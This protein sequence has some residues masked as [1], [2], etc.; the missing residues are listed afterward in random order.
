MRSNQKRTARITRQEDTDIDQKFYP[1]L[2]DL[3]IS[4]KFIRRNAVTASSGRQRG[5]VWISDLIYSHP[6]YDR[7]IVALVECKDH[8]TNLG[9]KDWNDAVAQ[10]QQK[11]LKQGLN[12]FFVTNTDSITRCYNTYDL[13]EVSIDGTVITEIQ[14]LPV[15]KAIQT[16]VSRVNSGVKY[17]TF[18]S[19]TPDPR[20]FRASLWELRQIF[21]AGGI[22]K[23]SEDSMIKTSLTFCILKLISEQQSIRRT[24]PETIMLWDEWR[25]GQLSRDMNNTIGDIT[26]LAQYRH[27]SDCLH[28]DDR[29]DSAACLKIKEE[30]GRFR[31]YASDFDFFGL[32][33]ESF[34]NAQLKKDFGEF[35]TPRHIIRTMVRLLLADE[36]SYRPL[37]ICDPACGTGGFLV[38]A[39]LFLESSYNSADASAD[40]NLTALKEKTFV[41]FDTNDKVAIPFART[42]MM[43]A[44]DGG[45]NIVQS[46]S[47]LELPESAY[48]YVLANV[49]YG[50]YGGDAPISSFGYTNRRRFE[51]LFVEK[52]VKSLKN[53]GRG[54]VI[55]PD[56][57]VEAT[58]YK[59]FRQK[60][61]FDAEMESI[62]SLP[63]FV[64][65]PYTGEKTYIL[66]FKRKLE[67]QK[68]KLQEN[69]VWHYIVDND[70]FQGG[71]K[72]YPIN[73]ND[74]P[75]LEAVYRKSDI[76]YK[77]GFVPMSAV[78]DET[79]YTLCSEFY[80]RK[81]EPIEIDRDL[82]EKILAEV[83]ILVSPN[84]NGGGE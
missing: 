50:E 47:L 68:G 55:V 25:G 71:K 46:D 42:N 38:E 1:K 64:F 12:S 28:I 80:L 40:E 18:A 29:L 52:I 20:R 7:H 35:Y 32:V 23:G 11:A 70:G 43:M 53:G 27:L 49:P 15:L 67:V 13:S 36:K 48:D 65:Q 77:A 5:D 22:S 82:F 83:E 10:G 17:R 58:S 3:G 30:I 69:P 60:F 61:L 74:L 57:L 8:S 19:N 81:K 79:F 66:F 4:R 73:D 39:L 63:S 76:H 31:L 34:A 44:D 26:Q 37:V 54:A 62:V 78:T 33:Y 84:G 56:G 24:I 9:D 16:Q 41:G 51:L 75:E 72:R 59:E 2:D 45:T 21:R 14:A 6:D